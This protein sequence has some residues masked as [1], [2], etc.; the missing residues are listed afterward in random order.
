VCVIFQGEDDEEEL[1]Q[2]DSGKGGDVAG[3]HSRPA[4]H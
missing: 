1:R 3:D 4:L 2:V